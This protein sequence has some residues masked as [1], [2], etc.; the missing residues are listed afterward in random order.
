MSNTCKLTQTCH[1]PLTLSQVIPPAV[2]LKWNWYLS[3]LLQSIC[4]FKNSHR[5]FYLFMNGRHVFESCLVNQ[6][7]ASVLPT[8]LAIQVGVS[9]LKCGYLPSFLTNLQV[10]QEFIQKIEQS[11]I[12]LHGLSLLVLKKDLAHNACFSR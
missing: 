7:Q 1:S 11:N 2:N 6:L 9:S 12:T 5:R 3:V 8:S 10:D 4:N